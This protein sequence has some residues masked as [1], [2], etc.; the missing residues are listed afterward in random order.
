[1]ENDKAWETLFEKYDVLNYID[2][3]GQFKISTAQMDQFGDSKNMVSIYHSTD[4]P[5]IFSDEKLSILPVTKNDYIISHFESHHKLESKT[6]DI[7]HTSIPKYIQSLNFNEFTNKLVILNRAL[8]SGIIEEFTEDSNIKQTFRGFMKTGEFNFTI[9]SKN[10]SLQYIRVENAE[11]KVD[12]IYEG[13]KYVSLFKVEIDSYEDFMIG[14]FYYP[15][16][17][18]CNNINKETKFIYL[19]Y[20]GNVYSLYEYEFQ[21]L[22]NYNSISLVKQKNY[23]ID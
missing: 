11:I 10:D 17:T 20:T 9:K 15:Y 19:E 22:N 12:A 13:L 2:K 5:Q 1:M 4:L 8:A 16:R 14:Q 3:F 7:I 21:E 23:V 6:Q 18:C